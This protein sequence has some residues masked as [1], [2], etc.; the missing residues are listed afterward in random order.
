MSE[1]EYL[2]VLVSI[3]VAFALSEI[4]AGWG[5]M[6]RGRDH[7]KVYWVHIAATL[8]VAALIIQFW[9]SAWQY[10]EMAI[11]FYHYAALL[12]SPLTCVLLAFVLTPQITD[13][14]KLDCRDYYYNNI[15]WMYPLAAVVIFELGLADYVIADGALATPKNLIRLIAICFI[16]LLAFNKKEFFHQAALGTLGLLLILFVSLNPILGGRGIQ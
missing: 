8:L 10:H 9:W 14:V 7:V 11:N 1:F 12:L 6:I 3:V 15:R 2:S 5:R 4:F 13:G 16:L